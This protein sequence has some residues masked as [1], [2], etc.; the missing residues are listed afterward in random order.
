MYVHAHVKIL[1]SNSVEVF[2]VIF[3]IKRDFNRFYTC[4][5]CAGSYRLQP[6]GQLRKLVLQSVH[7]ST[8]QHQF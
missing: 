3:S 5:Y 4:F 6:H 7:Y 1:H 8:A 2:F